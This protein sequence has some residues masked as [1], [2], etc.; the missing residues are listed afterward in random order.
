LPYFRAPHI[1]VALPARFMKGRRVVSDDELARMEVA[2]YGP[3]VYYND[4]SDAVFMST[5]AGTTV[6]DRTFMEAF[7][8]P[9]PG[10]NN[11]VSRTNFPVHGLLQTGPEELSFY[12]SR[13]YAQPTWHIRRYTL[14]VDGFASVNAPYHGGEMVTRVLTFSGA[15]LEINF[16][17]SAAGS[18]QVEIRDAENH[19]LPGYTVADCD[20]LVGDAIAR[21]V[22]WQG[23]TDVA[24]FVGTP[25]RLR[26]VLRDADLYAI[27]FG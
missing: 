20:T 8:R 16:A 5:R 15:A 14:R 13:D 23:K 25:V 10:Q 9:G 17:T 21:R 12:V 19:P 1:Y 3:Y 26:F 11:W 22:S 7:V 4:C 6:Y 27:K 2:S 24:R 18:V